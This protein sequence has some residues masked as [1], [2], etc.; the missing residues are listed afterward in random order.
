L[1]EGLKFHDCFDVGEG[2]E[3][4]K[5]LEVGQGDCYLGLVVWVA[6]LGGVFGVELFGERFVGVDLEGEGF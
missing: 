3:A 2:L 1:L 6:E 4:G 5:Q